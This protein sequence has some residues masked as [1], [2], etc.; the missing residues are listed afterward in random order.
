LNNFE[1]DELFNSYDL[2]QYA[3][4]YWVIHFQASP[5]HDLAQQKITTS[6]KT[7]F[8]NLTLLAII[9]GSVYQFQYSINE[10]IEFHLL[11][12]SVRRLVLGEQSEPALQTLLNLSKMKQ[13]VL[14]STEPN[15]FYCEAWR[16]ATSLKITTIVTL[17]SH[18]YI[19]F[20][21][22]LTKKVTHRSEIL[23]YIIRVQ[24]ESNSSS[25]EVLVYM[26]LLVTLLIETG[27]TEKAAQYSKQI[28][29]LKVTIYGRTFRGA[30]QSYERLTT[31]VR[32]STKTEDIHSINKSS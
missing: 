21:S 3:S 30:T 5:M 29:D 28:Y 18:R 27:E 6:F 2:L 13:L 20:S 11:A 25:K 9:E 17:C 14:K 12:L 19:N 16:L 7:C 24:R 32:K 31:T 15:E 22:T 8:P 1:L 23:E 4:R 26:E 10:A